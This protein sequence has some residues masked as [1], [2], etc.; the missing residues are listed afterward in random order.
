MPSPRMLLVLSENWTMTGGRCDLEA[1][2]RWARE[3]E[4]AGFDSVMLS[5]HLVLGPDSGAL[6][7]MPNPRE[8]ALPG[9]QDPGTP[10]PNSIVL[11]SAIAAVTARLRLVAG[12]ILAPLRHPLV[13]AKE[14]AT[15]DLLSKG[16]LVVLPTVSWSRDEYAALGVPFGKRG[17]LLDEHLAAWETLWRP[18]P[19]TYEGEHYAFSDV[20][21]EPKPYRPGGPELW[22][23]GGSLHGPLLR[24]LVR[25]GHG[26]N[27]LGRPA[28]EEL[29]KLRAAMAEAGRSMD[30]LEMIGGTRAVFP[31]PDAVADLGRALESVPE[32]MAQGF[33]TFCIKPSQ[34]TDDPQDVGRF[35]REVMRRVE[36][37]TS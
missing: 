27:P 34:F 15:L 2:I 24:R 23:G 8:Y 1:L 37:L 21:L 6:G 11:L 35:C 30:E 13:L 31:G 22:F 32:Q 36:R 18:S 25:Y 19:A 26:F 3:A 10:W 9:N 16:R 7:V 28:P 33:G 29:E 14:L 20:H 4:D 5:E 17:K 12:A